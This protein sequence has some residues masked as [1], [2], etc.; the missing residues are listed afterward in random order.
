MCRFVKFYSPYCPHC[1]HVAPTWQTLYEFYQTSAPLEGRVK[2][3][4]P[5]IDAPNS[6]HGY[7]S[8]HFASLN[9][10]AYGDACS[11]N[12]INAYPTFLLYKNG[13]QVDKYEGERSVKSFSS[14]VED[15]LEQIKPGSRPA[16]GL[17]VPKEG[18]RSVDGFIQPQVVEA[19]DKDKAAGIAMGEK[20]NEKEAA[21][22]TLDAPNS[23]ETAKTGRK[24]SPKK[25]ATPNAKGVSV[26]LTAESFQKQVTTS[27]DSWFIKFYAP[28]CQHCLH[29]APTW[30]QMAKE[31]KGQLNVG[32]VNCDAEPRLCKDAK[33]N[34][35]PT[36]YY[37]RGGERVEY[38]GLRGLGDLLSF[39]NKALDSDVK[40]V[41][42]ATFKEMEETEEVIFI[43]FFDQAT[44]SEDFAAL[45]RLTLSL[46]GHAKIVKT[47]SEILAKRFRISTWPRLAVSRSG[48]ATFFTPI[49][50]KDMRDFRQVFTW[51]QSVWL[52]IVPELTA[53]NAREIMG[54]N[55]AV[56]GI[57][58][59]DKPDQFSES[60]NELKSAALEWMEKRTL[61][62]QL[63]R[64]ELRDAKQLRIE[65]AEDRDDQRALRQAKSRVISIS[66]DTF[67]RQVRFAWVDGVFW[68]R[69]L[70]ST[71]GVDVAN[72]ERVIIADQDVSV[73]FT[74]TGHEIMLTN[75]RTTTSG[76]SPTPAP[77]SYHPAHPSSKHSVASQATHQNSHP[78]PPSESSRASST[79]YVTWEF[80][81]L[82][83][84]SLFWLAPSSRCSIS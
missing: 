31:L 15:K 70:R 50:P 64:Q 58:T 61:Q 3:A 62:F 5:G 20:Q 12:G 76:T 72:G 54:G 57:L 17:K 55:F 83:S 81:I 82:G 24:K 74:S 56:L 77:S 9:C 68:E 41:D 32:E 6:F 48:R 25:G 51:M 53:A 43:Y 80:T 10:V 69:W 18:D 45:D 33:V 13:E 46:I 35:Y 42:A 67:R 65:E 79:A 60:K 23:A 14:F 47:D 27:Q 78:N 34:A 26:P 4:N 8:F 29:L 59:R 52:P 16:Q 11:K 44:T 36:I 84:Q 28:W 21:A 38:E 66:E 7:Y 19:K 49:A 73:A 1:V 2:N 22:K 71:Y 39:A 75:I 30:T 63:E 40:Y 37:F